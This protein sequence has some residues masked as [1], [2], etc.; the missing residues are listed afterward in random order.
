MKRLM[1]SLLSIVFFISLSHAQDQETSTTTA[2]FGFKAGLNLAHQDIRFGPN[3][4][5]ANETG[6]YLGAAVNISLANKISLQP[7]FMYSSSSYADE[8]GNLQ[9][10]HLPV[11]GNYE[12]AEGFNVSLGPELQYALKLGEADLDASYVNRLLLG[13]D[14]GLSYE[15]THNF[16]LQIRYHLP[17]TKVIDAGAVT[18]RKI[19][20]L[21]LGLVLFFDKK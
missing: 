8:D 19:D 21:Q 1:T 6:F 16:L 9:L 3:E 4:K 11:L 2:Q 17:V 12:F 5:T 10:L 7:E 20:H 14:F 15:F 13:L 18:Y